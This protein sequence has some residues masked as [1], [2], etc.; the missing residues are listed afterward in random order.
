MRGEILEIRRY[1]I[2]DL[3]PER[4]RLPN[5]GTVEGYLESLRRHYP[6]MPADAFVDVVDFQVAPSNSAHTEEAQNATAR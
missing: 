4:L 3:T 1:R 6:A 5:G 2:N